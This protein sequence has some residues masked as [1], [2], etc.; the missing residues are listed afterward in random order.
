MNRCENEALK[1][2]DTIILENGKKIADNLNC[3]LLLGAVGGSYSLNL[4]NR[5][6]DIDCYLIVEGRLQNGLFQAVNLDGI[7]IDFMCV[8]IHELL[9]ECQEFKEQQR[10]YPTR[11][12]RSHE[13]NAMYRKLKDIERPGFKR[14]I[15]IR[16]FLAEEILEFE[17]GSV[18]AVY[19]KIKDSLM[20]IEI[21]DYH[22]NRAYGNYYEK[23]EAEEKVLLRKYLYTISEIS[24]CNMIL[25]HS[26]V[27]MDYKRMIAN[28]SCICN[29][30]ELSQLCY[31]LWAE[32]NREIT[33]KSKSYVSAEPILNTWI[34]KNLDYIFRKM[35]AEEL[36]LKEQIYAYDGDKV[37]RFEK[38]DSVLDKEE[39]T[40]GSNVV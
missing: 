9:Q 10:Q 4:A 34:V 19:S 36:S 37:R 27:I 14:E 31:K 40:G 21:C 30:R 28:A 15:P 1:R 32:N 26:E 22:F 5:S 7:Q 12:Y 6:G 23:I 17:K 16:I 29:D 33:K 18:D 8:D 11:F 2:V 13:E 25:E 24:I 3:K 39:H 38:V 20:L 35:K